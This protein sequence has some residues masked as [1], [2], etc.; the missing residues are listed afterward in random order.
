V[1]KLIA[2]GKD[3]PEALARLRD[4]LQHTTVLGVANNRAFLMDLL[5]HPSVAVNDV[6]TELIDGWLT[7]WQSTSAACGPTAPEVAAA[8]AAWLWQTRATAGLTDGGAW[9]DDALCAW[10]MGGR[11]EVL[12]TLR[13]SSDGAFDGGTLA[14]RVGVAEQGRA[15]RVRVDDA[16]YTVDRHGTGPTTRCSVD[17]HHL[18][19]SFHTTSKGLQV[20]RGGEA[21]G[22]LVAPL[23]EL[24]AGQA[25]AAQGSVR[26]PMMGLISSVAV[27]QGAVVA[28][29]ERLATLESMKMET[30]IEAPVAGTVRWVGCVAQDQ[31]ERHQA[32]FTIDTE[33]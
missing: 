12:H 23:R 25:A 4:A 8:T 15:L 5:A 24:S 26:A 30:P 32:L 3:R 9:H 2:H 28:L 22:L 21:M 18:P 20:W 6:H 16:T 19:L 27:A 14:W 7:E 10:R 29:G 13:V 17:G 11:D 33:A 31:V 1:A